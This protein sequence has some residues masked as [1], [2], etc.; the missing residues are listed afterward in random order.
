MSGSPSVSLPPMVAVA[1]VGAMPVEGVR[2]RVA[3]GALLGGAVT[4][5]VVVFWAA[6]PRPFETETTA[7]NTPEFW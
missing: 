2:P 1:S 5:I 4:V 6:P 7:L 3:V